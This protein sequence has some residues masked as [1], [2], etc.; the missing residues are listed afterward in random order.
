MN[1]K[2]IKYLVALFAY[3]A[4]LYPLWMAAKD[5]ELAPGS[6]LLLSLFPLFGIAAFAML[7]LHAISGVFEPWLRK[8]FDFDRFVNITSTLIFICI[9]L[10]PLLLIISP[11]VTLSNL[12][13]HGGLYIWLGVIGWL[14][15]LTYD[16]GKALKKYNFFARNWNK[17]LLIST[18]GFLLIF[19]HSLQLGSDLQLN[20]MR[21][22][23]I[24]YGTTAILAT[25]YTYGVKRLAARTTS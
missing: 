11:M 2:L 20:P 25:I 22:L 4:V 14:L 13:L 8:H 24:F 9:I 5:L 12:L 1:Q 7:W 23:W 21:S 3:L 17:I 18:I 6:S 15:L 10:H 19:F 16:A